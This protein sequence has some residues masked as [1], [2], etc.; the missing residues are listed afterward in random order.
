MIHFVPARQR[1]PASRDPQ[2]DRHRLGTRLPAGGRVPDA[3]PEYRRRTRCSSFPSRWRSNEL[4]S[5]LLDFG[6]LEGRCLT[7]HAEIDDAFTTERLSL[8]TALHSET[9]LCPTD[10][11]DFWTAVRR[12]AVDGAN[13]YATNLLKVYPK[14]TT[15]KREKQI[16]STRR[17]SRGQRSVTLPVIAANTRTV[18]GIITQRG[19][20][21]AGCKGVILGP[22]RDIVNITHGPIGCGFYSW[23]TRRNQTRHADRR[24]RQLHDLLLLD[25]HAGREH[26]LRR[27]EEAAAGDPGSLRP[28]PPQGDRRVL[29]LPGRA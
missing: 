4:E 16:S 5:L 8:S 3:G 12:L 28:V 19:C 27:R 18:P 24:T 22:T 14:K 13:R 9:V 11:S 10:A 7:L 2:D 23:L 15:R 29:H 20:S 25:R 21:Y 1:R 26:H 17:R 6:V